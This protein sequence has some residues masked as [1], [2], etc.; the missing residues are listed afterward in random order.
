MK[1]WSQKDMDQLMQN[2]E[3]GFVYL[4]TPMCGTC[5]MAGRML[6][7]VT[8]LFPDLTFGKADLNYYPEWA[9]K[10]EVQSVPCLLIIK[11]GQVVDRIFAF[12]SV[13]Y[14]HERI[15]QYLL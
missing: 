9:L 11:D 13:P 4:Y 15:K 5:Q 14:L 1:E 7:V 10:F 6:E 2:G 3:V 12:H 8:Q